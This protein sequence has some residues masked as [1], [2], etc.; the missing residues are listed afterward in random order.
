MSRKAIL[1]G[2]PGIDGAFAVA[3]A[4]L[5][6]EIEALGLIATPGN[7]TAE[8][9]TR[10]VHTLIEQLDPPRWP[11]LG[12]APAITY[13]LDA[14]RLHGGNGLGGVDF[15]CAQLHHPHPGEKLL[16]DLVR[17]DPKQVT[18]ILMGPATV[19]AR[20]L[21]RDPE[22]PALIDRLI[23]L[24]GTWHEPGDA[25]PVT[26][27]HF[28]CDPLAARQVVHSGARILLLPLDVTRKVVFSP[29]DLL[30]L[31]APE[32]PASRFLRQIVPHGIHATASIY[33]TEGLYLQD[34]LGIVALGEPD[35]LT[36]KPAVVDVEVRGELTRGM[37]VFDARWGGTARA[38]VDLA[39]G[40][41]VHGVRKYIQSTLGAG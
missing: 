5:D 3:L 29:T 40:V 16:C 15:P 2:D 39:V 36:I 18:V 4:M 31:P 28:A 21:D 41:D 37:S 17:Q 6:P 13:E 26:E 20:A 25:G 34:V 10:N 33:G 27:F 22:L 9:A 30:N 8:Q 32:S 14:V 19:F 24:G 11:R 12:A 38:N 7:V 23:V 1:I 35:L